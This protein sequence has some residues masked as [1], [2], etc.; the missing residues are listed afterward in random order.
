M[1]LESLILDFKRL[2]R[3]GRPFAWLDLEALDFNIERV[4]SHL[5]NKKLRV[6]SK[7][8]RC[9]EV[10]RYIQN[11]VPDLCGVMSYSAGETAFLLDR[12][13]QDLLCAYPQVDSEGILG[14]EIAA[15]AKNSRVCWMVDRIE[16]AL[17]LGQVASQ[18]DRRMRVCIDINLSTPLPGLY[19]GTRRSQLCSAE[20]FTRFLDELLRIETL[21]VVGLMGYEAQIAGLAEKGGDRLM[22]TA[23]PIIR[24]LK[25]HSK[26]KL[27]KLR[28]DCVAIARARCP[29]L[30]F[31]N[32]GGSGS[33]DFS[34]AQSEVTEVTVGSAFYKPGYFALMDSMQDF[35]PAAGFVLPIT[36]APEPGYVVAHSGGF[37][38]SGSAG[39]DKLPTVIH[40]PGLLPLDQEGFGEVQTPLKVPPGTTVNIGDQVFCQ[41]AK[42]GELGEHFNELLAFRNEEIVQRM[43]TYRGEGKCFH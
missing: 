20:G 18:V 10:L 42:A 29:E 13:F 19:F 1:V 31:V 17:L 6:A 38:A 23:A 41:H 3:L 36:R 8:V 12:G 37:V 33:L 35:K 4:Q 9:V 24:A 2:P 11:R 27:S 39:P 14:A 5:G 34:V 32:G 22:R 28:K 15:K 40:P 21:Q 26:Q 30:E 25:S 7:S 16:Q 43:P